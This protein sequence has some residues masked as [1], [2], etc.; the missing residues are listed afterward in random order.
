MKQGK[1]T[2][3]LVSGAKREPVDKPVPVGKT[4]GRAKST[5]LYPGKGDRA[6]S[7]T[8]SAKPKGTQGRH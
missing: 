3:S 6:P 1:A 8:T 5:E 7:M 2:T 4:I